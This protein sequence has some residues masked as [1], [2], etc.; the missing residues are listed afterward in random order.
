MTRQRL[1]GRRQ[2]LASRFLFATAVAVATTSVLACLGSLR[3]GPEAAQAGT[4]AVTRAAAGQEFGYP[5]KP[6]DQEHPVRAN[7]GDPRMNFSGPPTLRTLMHGKGSF[8]F[9]QGI[10][11]SAPNGT[12]VYPVADGTV[13]VKKADWIRV[14]SENGH[15]FEYWHIGPLVRE[16]DHV[17][18]RQT[19]LGLIKR[20][21]GHVHLTEFENGRAVNPLLPGRLTPYT[22]TTRPSIRSIALRKRAAGRDLLPGFVRGTV[23]IVANALDTPTMPVGGAWNGMPTTPSAISWRIQKVNGVIVV[24]ER[25]AVDFRTTVPERSAFWQVYARGT[26]QNMCVFGKHYSF[27]QRGSYLFKLGRF[28]THSLRDGV[29]ELVVTASDVRGNSDSQSLRITVHNRRG[30]SG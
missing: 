27:L 15:T 8:S 12:A 4:Q 20:P 2:N 11:I 16:G 13:T 10:D 23:E 26:Y 25:F 5:I 14:N 30:W 1:A 18:A 24:P 17:V 21:S 22:D 29:Y 28:D 9:H 7:F 3:S 6:F 19:V